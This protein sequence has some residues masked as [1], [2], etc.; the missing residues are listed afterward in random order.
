MLNKS[1]KIMAVLIAVTILIPGV[2]Q[3][4]LAAESGEVVRL[5]GATRV[6]TAIAV[7]REVYSQSNF[8]ILAGANGGEVDALAGTLLAKA[9]NAPLLLTLKDRVDPALK[10]ELSRLKA[11]TI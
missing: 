5:Q 8:V 7:S 3:K 11:K 2:A 10:A 1:K 6:Q 4:A 9:R